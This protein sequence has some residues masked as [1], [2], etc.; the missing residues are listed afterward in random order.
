MDF[1]INNLQEEGTQ[2]NQDTWEHYSNAISQ[3][4]IRVKNL[5]Q[6]CVDIEK[7]K[8]KFLKKAKRDMKIKIKEII[9]TK[10]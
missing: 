1:K 6:H 8:E 4:H 9:D 2:K 5:T 10:N 3:I 7:S